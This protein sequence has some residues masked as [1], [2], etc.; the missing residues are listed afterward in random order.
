MIFETSNQIE[1]EKA[2][3]YFNFLLNG[4]KTIEIKAKRKRRSIPQNSY[5]HLILSAFGLNFGYT[6]EEVK[7]QIFKEHL[8]SDIFYEGEKEG[9]VKVKSWRSSANLNTKEMTTAINRFLDF[10]S[11]LGYLL[12]DPQ[13]L[14]YIQQLEREV[15]NAK[16]YL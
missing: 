10:S 5:L 11:K 12:P 4:S 2:K 3:V 14:V 15:N 1:A 16:Q 13:N 9:I 8:N 6:L 7:Q